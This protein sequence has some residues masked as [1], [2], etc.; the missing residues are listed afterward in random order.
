VNEIAKSAL[1]A[2]VGDGAIKGRMQLSTEA[3]SGL[4]GIKSGGKVA[5]FSADSTESAGQGTRLAYTG[6]A[7][8]QAGNLNERS[9]T[10]AA[11][12]G[13]KRKEEAGSKALCPAS[14]RRGRSCGLGSPYSKPGTAEDGLPHPECGGAASGDRASIALV[15]ELRNDRSGCRLRCVSGTTGR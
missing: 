9:T 7:N 12:G 10:K 14:D 5:G 1:V 15:C 11:I 6:L 3:A 8:R 13:K 4:C 2:S